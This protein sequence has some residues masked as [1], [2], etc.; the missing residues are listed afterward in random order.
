MLRQ[1]IDWLYLVAINWAGDMDMVNDWQKHGFIVESQVKIPTKAAGAV[2]I[3]AQVE[4]DRPRYDGQTFRDYFYYLMNIED[5]EDFIPYAKRLALDFLNSA[6]IL[7]DETGLFD[8]NHPESYVEYYRASFAAKLE[9]I[10]EILRNQAS[11]ALGWRTGRTREEWVRGMLDTA[12]FDQTDGAWLRYIANA[13]P[14]DQ[15]RALLFEIWSDEIGGGNSAL[16]HGNFFTVLMNSAG[17]ILPPVSSRAYADNPEIDESSYIGAVFQLAI[18]LH[19]E[20]FFSGTPRNDVISRVGGTESCSRH[21]RSGV[22]RHRRAVLA[23]ARRNRQC[24]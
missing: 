16:H 5:Y 21:Q 15:V 19:S 4:I 8:P 18:S 23:N 20:A 11:T 17:K 6:Q 1:A 2:T 9:Q 10:Y 13:G 24:H 22:H 12:P 7:I 3:V 14:S